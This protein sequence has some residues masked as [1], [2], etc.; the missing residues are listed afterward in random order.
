MGPS[1]ACAPPASDW[2][3]AAP[4]VGPATFTHATKEFGADASSKKVIATNFVTS[5]LLSFVQ[6][7]EVGAGTVA[8]KQIETCALVQTKHLTEGQCGRKEGRM[9]KRCW[10]A[11]SP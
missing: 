11:T 10:E 6:V 3:P 1:V 8:P 5:I 2:K 9:T 7:E 4:V